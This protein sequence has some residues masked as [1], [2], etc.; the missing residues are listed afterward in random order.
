MGFSVSATM[1]IFFVAFL[2]LFSVLYASVNDAFDNVSESFD[3]KYEDMQDRALTELEFVT[4]T[5]DRGRNTLEITIR[6]SGSVVLGT[7]Y[8]ELLIDGTLVPFIDRTIGGVYSGYWL[9]TDVLTITAED[10]GLVF[11]EDIEF[12]TVAS[13][14]GRLSAPTNLSVGDKIY[15][16]D[17]TDIDVFDLDGTL[18]FTITDGMNIESPV[19]LKVLGD[20]VYVLDNNSHV[21]RLALNGTW[22]DRIVDDPAN[23]SAPSSVAVDADYIYLVDS[24]DHIDR[25]NRSTGAFVDCVIANG[26]TMTNPLDVFVGSH[27][28][29]LDY[30]TGEY[31]LDRY[32][33]D[34]SGGTE[35]IVSG[36]L[37]APTDVSA[38]AYGLDAQYIYIG[39]G[40]RVLVFDES[41]S[42][43]GI[44]E[45]GLS[46]AVTGV[47]ATGRIF[48]SDGANGLVVE[49]L[50]TSLKVVAENGVSEITIL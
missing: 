32:D 39:D 24:S 47:D 17:G 41:G 29:V 13:T 6:N 3:H 26:G 27:I 12:R 42:L 5:Y 2:I 37:S 14:S 16:V 19:D 18:D 28:L 20:Y 25:Y 11:S 49:S 4:L 22:V 15:I 43:E 45:D 33:L 35:I 9:P 36:I 21:D 8:T 46:D 40:D 23:T 48:V 10:P 44:V 1:A 34:G 31:H 30:S 38:S 7:N 50:G